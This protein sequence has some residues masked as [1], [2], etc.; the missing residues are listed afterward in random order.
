MLELPGVTLCCI[1]TA[2][3]ELALRALRRSASLVRFARTLLL[4]DATAAIPGID[5][6]PIASLASRDEYSR[7]VLKQLLRYIETDHVLL[8]QWDG[9]VVHPDAWRDDFLACD[10]LGAKWFWHDASQNV[11]NGG[12]S[13]RSRKLLQA[14]QDERIRLSGA[15][16]E[17][18][19]RVFRPLLE[20]EHG[21]RFGSETLADAFAF[22]AAYPVRPTFG[23]H[24]LFNFCRVMAD[25][26]LAGLVPLF[27]AE[28]ARSPQLLQLGR[29]CVALG[30]WRAAEA[31]FRCILDADP[32]HAEAATRLSAAA[33]HTAAGPRVGRND[34]C[35]CGS[36]KRYKHCHGASS[37]SS[38]ATD[39][40]EQ[41]LS[42]AIAL[43]RGGADDDKATAE[44]IYREILDADPGNATARHFLGVLH[45]QR[46]EIAAALPL[47]ESAAA[48]RPGEAE[49][50]NNLGLALAAADRDAEAVARY[51]SALA[52]RPD[53]ALAWNNLGL[54]LQAQNLVHEAIDAYR[55][56]LAI[57][58]AFARARWNLSLALLLDRQF[59]E[60]WLE[61]D[62]RLALPELGRNRHLLPG[63]L[64]DGSALARRTLLVT[65]EQGLGDA[66]Q[67]ARYAAALAA[68]GVRCLI[69]CSS[70]LAPLLET[71]PGVAGVSLESEPLPRYDAYVPLLSLPRILGTGPD[72]IP[73][74]VPYI[75]IAE[76]HRAAARAVF[77]RKPPGRRIGL[78]WAGN[79]AY[80]ND[81]N[82]SMT[83][84]AVAPLVGVEGTAWF[85]LQ[86]GE[87]AKQLAPQVSDRVV[88]LPAG[89]PL[90]DTAALVAELDLIV[91]SDT[92]IAH[93]AGA[94]AKPVWVIVPFAPDWR[95]ELGRDDSPWYPTMRL[96]RPPRPRDFASAVAQ[97]RRELE[98]V[99]AP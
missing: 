82:R 35:P 75:T 52:L 19:C 94:L 61:Y 9:Y 37:A 26:E 7:F 17:T 36:G 91:T 13:L 79:P 34:P 92:A 24:G 16:D 70:A 22:E 81:R 11:G 46:G 6:R 5:V 63:T 71:V 20:K 41:R 78:R 15:E 31:I 90:V 83:F 84:S 72:T 66:L 25:E 4:T 14:L 3:P 87:A 55:R 18:I 95:W 42:A 39:A 47:L 10:Y 32:R 53:H 43:H 44:S 97:I 57:D 98:R 29:N 54:A 30:Q 1:D 38:Q 88:P 45:Y 12:F 96:F 99:G 60:G 59:A 49:F 65:V 56:A 27:T 74:S 69:R 85:S 51:R 77:A 89:T 68:A 21:V 62:A 28:I 58:P 33:R 86:D 50:H 8:V 48:A 93:L 67:F 64:W 73:A 2:H 40:P 23:F 76:E 80:A